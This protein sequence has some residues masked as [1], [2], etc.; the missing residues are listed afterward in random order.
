MTAPIF[1]HNKPEDTYDDP[2]HPIPSLT[3]LDI[4]TVLKGGGAIL[5][6]IIA[7]PLQSDEYSLNRLLNKIEGYLGHILSD[8]FAKQAKVTEPTPENTSIEVRI[9]PN[10]CKE[11]FILLEQSKAWVRENKATLK[12]RPLEDI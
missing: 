10:S 2:S 1:Q 6:I 5:T 8:D 4:C 3:H 12:I 11:A 9:H 7:D